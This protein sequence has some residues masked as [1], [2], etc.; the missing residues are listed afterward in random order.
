MVSKDQFFRTVDYCST[1]TSAPLR[2]LAD[3]TVKIMDAGT[4]RTKVITISATDS[5]YAL[6]IS[7]K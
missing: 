7:S 3:K 1:F 6:A 2:S 5:L 4:L